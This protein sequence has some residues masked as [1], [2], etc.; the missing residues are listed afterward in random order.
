MNLSVFTNVGKL[1]LTTTAKVTGVVSKHAPEILV[2]AGL[3]GGAATTV[4][5]CKQT[6]KAEQVLE[7]AQLGYGRIDT[8]LDE[9]DESKYSLDDAKQDMDKIHKATIGKMIR[10]YAPVAALGT[11]SAVCVL[12]GFKVLRMRNVALVA[13]YTSLEAGY[14]AYRNRVVEELGEEADQHFRTGSVYKKIE[15]EVTD[16]E[17]GEVKKK[18][19]K[20]EVVEEGVQPIDYTINFCREAVHI[21]DRKDLMSSMNFIINTENSCNLTLQAYKYITLNEVRK[22]LGVP[23]VSHGQI[24]GWCYD[25]TGDD[26][27]RLNPRVIYDEELGH[28]TII[29]DPNVDGIMFNKIDSI[30][31]REYA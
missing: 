29:L 3:V 27:I 16:E 4:F 2:G 25:G 18:K 10:V 24:V 7:E 14:K 8:A 11:A 17:T 19:L 1:A 23:E 20:A 31:R 5:A 30:V 6:L 12:C 13:A 28:D 22:C 21:R 15:R 26:K 9:V